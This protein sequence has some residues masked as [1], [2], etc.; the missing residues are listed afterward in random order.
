MTHWRWFD[1]NPRVLSESIGL[2]L[3]PAIFYSYD[4]YAVFFGIFSFFLVGFQ[5]EEGEED[6]IGNEDLEEDTDATRQMKLSCKLV[7]FCVAATVGHGLGSTKTKAPSCACVPQGH[8]LQ[9][10]GTA[11]SM[12]FATW[13]DL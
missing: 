5:E 6:D 2:Y 4:T 11:H 13:K 7:S 9:S 8:L 12:P 3:Y 10:G 1:K